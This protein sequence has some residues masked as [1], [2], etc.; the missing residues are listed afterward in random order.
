MKIFERIYRIF[1]KKEPIK[2]ESGLIGYGVH[3]M[4]SKIHHLV[5]INTCYKNVYGSDIFHFTDEERRIIKN[6][7]RKEKIKRIENDTSTL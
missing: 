5:Q 1:K 4:P 2:P 3:Y 7:I 6:K